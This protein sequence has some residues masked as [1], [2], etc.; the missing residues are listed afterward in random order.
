MRSSP[1]K[2]TARPA[3]LPVAGSNRSLR[4][5]RRQASAT[6][7]PSRG[8]TSRKHSFCSGRTARRADRNAPSGLRSVRATMWLWPSTSRTALRT[9]GIR[10]RRAR[11]R[12]F[13][14]MLASSGARPPAGAPRASCLRAIS[15]WRI[16]SRASAMVKVPS[17]DAL[18]VLGPRGHGGERRGPE[19]VHRL[20]AEAGSRVEHGK[21]LEG[22]RP[23]AHLLFELPS[24][25]LFR[26][27][28]HRRA[29]PRAAPTPRG[30]PA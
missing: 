3:G 27:S 25:A 28:R 12:S 24:R 9:N 16:I 14:V 20:V 8:S 10:R 30:R 26:R 29:C 11:R 23:Q 21:G 5:T 15:P 13:T 22:P 1:S 17:L 19:E 2:R 4:Q 6:S 7:R 18:V